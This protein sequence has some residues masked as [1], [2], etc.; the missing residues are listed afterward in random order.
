MSI[1]SWMRT[2]GDPRLMERIGLKFDRLHYTIAPKAWA[3]RLQARDFHGCTSQDHAAQL[4]WTTYEA[5]HELAQD[6]VATLFEAQRDGPRIDATVEHERTVQLEGEVEVPATWWSALFAGLLPRWLTS[7]WT[8]LVPTTTLTTTVKHT[9]VE[10]VHTY[11]QR[12]VYIDPFL[13]TRD[14]SARRHGHFVV[15]TARYVTEE[16]RDYLD[17]LERERQASLRFQP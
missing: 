11:T 6:Y 3:G 2:A 16:G 14:L 17:H 9:Y 8:W 12:W 15:S 7:R 5:V 4:V 13:T 10:H 1:D